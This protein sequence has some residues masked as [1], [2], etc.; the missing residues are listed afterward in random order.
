MKSET[1]H[2]Y[3]AGERIGLDVVI[4]EFRDGRFPEEIFGSYPSIGSL[5][6]VYGAMTFILEH[7]KEID[8][9]LRAQD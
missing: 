5:A 9:D 4:H 3:V 7:P 1:A 8:S 2:T 6:K